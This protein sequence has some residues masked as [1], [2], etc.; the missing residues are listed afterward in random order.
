MAKYSV[1]DFQG[2]FTVD[3]VIKK[4]SIT[5]AQATKTINYWLS[6]G[7]IKDL[8]NGSYA[9]TDVKPA[10]DAKTDA[11]SKPAADANAKTADAAK[12][13]TKDTTE[14]ADTAKTDT[15][16]TTATTDAAKT[17]AKP[18]AD[19]ATVESKPAAKKPIK[20]IPEQYNKY[21]TLIQT[22]SVDV[23]KIFQVRIA[24]T[25]IEITAKNKHDVI[26]VVTSRYNYP[27]KA[28]DQIIELK[29]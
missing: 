7:Y 25:D 9:K 24:N 18:A 20:E 28:I 6:K 26:Q 13:D 3:D 22:E 5:K 14:T 1:N 12:T 27:E 4:Y 15:K 11:N 19:K 29:S 10:A 16:D 21:K 17:D 23:A 8:G 2:D